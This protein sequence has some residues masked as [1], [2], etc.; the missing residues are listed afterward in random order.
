MNPEIIQLVIEY[1][2]QETG[3]KAASAKHAQLYDW[4]QNLA[5]VCL[6]IK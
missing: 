4:R 6:E 2:H 3:L 1:L 5:T